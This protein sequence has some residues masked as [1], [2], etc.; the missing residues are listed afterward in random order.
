MK[1]RQRA[2]ISVEVE[3]MMVVCPKCKSEI[4]V[5]EEELEEGELLSC[6]ECDGDFEVASVE[7]LKLTAVIDEEE[8]NEEEE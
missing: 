4:D 1:A 8:A 3:T 2:R 5:E 6:L 7:P